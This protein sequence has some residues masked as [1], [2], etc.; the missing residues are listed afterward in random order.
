MRPGIWRLT[1]SSVGYKSCTTPEYRVSAATPF[2]EVE[3]EEDATQVEAVT[4]R[5]SP[6]RVTTESP[7][8]LKVIGMQEIEK[9]LCIHHM[10]EETGLRVVGAMYHIEDGSVEFL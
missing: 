9:S 1:V 2:I 3:L 10:E 4:V 8:S 6:F 5:P 7:V